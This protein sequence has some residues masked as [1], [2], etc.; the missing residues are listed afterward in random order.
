MST[1]TASLRVSAECPRCKMHLILPEWSE[2][3]VKRETI[4]IWH[5]PICGNKFE[6]IDNNVA[7]PEYEL[8][9]ELLPNLLVD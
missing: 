3:V 7:L 6:T 9:Q 5:C 2:C 8:A 4:Y 1:S